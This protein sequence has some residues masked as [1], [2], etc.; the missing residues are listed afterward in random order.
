MPVS[1]RARRSRNTKSKKKKE[2]KKEQKA[3][4]K[5][6]PVPKLKTPKGY[7]PPSQYRLKQL[8]KGRHENARHGAMKVGIGGRAKVNDST[9]T[10]DDLL[11]AL[12]SHFKFDFDP[13][14][15]ECNVDA[16]TLDHW[17]KSNF[18][19]PPYSNLLMKNFLAKGIEEYKKKNYSVFLIPFRGNRKY[20]FKYIWPN[21]SEIWLINKTV[22]FKQY[23]LPF[24]HP[25]CLVVFGP[26]RRPQRAK[27]RTL[28]NYDFMVIIP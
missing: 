2:N 27:Q 23:E 12:H 8:R 25:L 18:V 14:P 28:G 15:L 13:C 26:K 20:W 24:P 10:P 19:N 4:G 22:T 6:L 9:S 3:P 21:A 16:L 1:R 17:G 5:R 7:K 11:A